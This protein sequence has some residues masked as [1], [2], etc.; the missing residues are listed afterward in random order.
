[1]RNYAL[2]TKMLPKVWVTWASTKNG[3]F[4]Q[5]YWLNCQTGKKKSTPEEWMYYE[6]EYRLDSYRAIP[7]GKCALGINWY[8]KDN[9]NV[10]VKNGCKVRY[11]YAKY[12]AD[13]DS[14]EVAAVGVDTTRKEEPHLWHF[15]GD[16]FFIRRDKSV[17]NQSGN[18]VTRFSL[19]EYHTAYS[20]KEMLHMLCRLNTSLNFVDEFKKFIGADYFTIG[21][22]TSVVI[23]YPWHIQRWY[24]TVQKTRGKGKEQKLTDE[25]TSI[26]LSDSSSFAERYPEVCYNPD[27]LSYRRMYIKGI[28]YFEKVNDDWDVLRSF[29]RYPNNTLQENWRM[30]IDKS[31]RTRMVSKGADG[32]VPS[33][34]LDTWWGNYTRLVNKDEAVANCNRIKYALAAAADDMAEEKLVGF[35]IFALRFPE[36]EQIIKLGYARKIQY[37]ADSHTPKADLKDLFGGYYNDKEKNIL[38]KVG[39]TKHQFDRHMSDASHYSTRALTQMRKMFGDNLSHLDN[40]SFDKYYGGCVELSSR[41]WRSIDDRARLLGFDMMRFFKNLVRL[42]EKRGNVFAL[43]NDTLESY[44]GLHA[45]TAPDVDWYFDDVSDLV[46][47]HDAVVELKR[48]QDAERRAM[49][50]VGEAERRKKEE[51]RRA[52]VDEKRKVYEYEDDEYIIRLPKDLKEIVQEG[53]TQHICIG[54]YTSRHANGDTNLFFLCKKDAEDTPF[55]AIEMSNYKQVVQIHG[56]C[57]EWLGRH[58]EAI[59]TVVRWLRKND[60]TCDQ[61]ILT[62][63]ANGY[64]RVNDYVPM[65]VVD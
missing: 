33:K 58:P 19:Y 41:F 23:Q 49:W 21:N 1:M 8:T 34:K 6:G 59:P 55:Y 48:I 2:D 16:R 22:G 40:E 15:I 53:H 5:R 51:E 65:P 45:D 32:W 12:H 24:E 54:G 26:E 31:G 38:R 47:T 43:A 28:V 36:V 25:L 44:M 64:G 56:S 20:A 13:I 62:C 27:Q 17:V 29:H 10:W 57:N 30:Y 46:R 37:M 50:S 60:I 9:K 39:M 18:V 42:K 3:E 52:K 7:E 61:K 35:L 14:L 63:T 11:A 4:N